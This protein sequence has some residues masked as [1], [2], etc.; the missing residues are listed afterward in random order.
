MIRKSKSK[1]VFCRICDEDYQHLTALCEAEGNCV[2]GVLRTAL[3]DFL[4]REHG[5]DAEISQLRIL[6]GKVDNL[7]AAIDRLHGLVSNLGQVQNHL[8]QTSEA[9]Q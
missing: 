8:A 2:S 7:A 1:A 3:A 4:Y 9:A 6:A 5:P